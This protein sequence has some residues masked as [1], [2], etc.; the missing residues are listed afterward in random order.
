MTMKLSELANWQDV[1]H[2]AGDVSILVHGREL[3]LPLDVLELL[4]E[5]RVLG[6]DIGDGR[7]LRLHIDGPPRPF[8][9]Q[10]HHLLH[11]LGSLEDEGVVVSAKQGV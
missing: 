2:L 9:R 4:Q 7:G 5:V 6:Q 10:L 8:T 11:L 1:G 3:K